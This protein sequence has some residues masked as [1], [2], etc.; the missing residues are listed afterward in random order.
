MES[1]LF[2][3]SCILSYLRYQ[4]V[5]RSPVN[6]IALCQICRQQLDIISCLRKY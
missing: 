1:N 2:S 5:K 3:G 6:S 4:R